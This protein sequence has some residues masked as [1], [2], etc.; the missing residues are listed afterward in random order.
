MHFT[1]IFLFLGIP[2]IL[3]SCGGPERI[4]TKDFDSPEAQAQELK[5]NF[6]LLKSS[7]GKRDQEL[8]KAYLMAFPDTWKNYYIIFGLNSPLYGQFDYLYM[9]D[10]MNSFEKEVVYRKVFDFS[11]GGAYGKNTEQDLLLHVWFLRDSYSMCQVTLEYSNEQIESVFLFM[12]DRGHPEWNAAKFEELY[13]VIEEQ[14]IGLAKLF[15]HAYNR[16]LENQ[17][18][19]PD[20]A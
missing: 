2:I 3:F 7:Q 8:E 1:R 4:K 15:S 5:E 14:D 17:E 20:P 16:L 11:I 13:K 10:D 6:A 9:L 19:I 18:K 12:L